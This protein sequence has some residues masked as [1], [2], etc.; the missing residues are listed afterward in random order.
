[1]EAAGTWSGSSPV[2]G[3]RTPLGRPDVPEV[4]IIGAPAVRGSG[5]PELSAPSMVSGVNPGISPA[6]NLARG[7]IPAACAASA[8]T[9]ANLSWA[10]NAPAPL[11]PR[12]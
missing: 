7:A 9:A 4:Y 1:M 6:A 5:R 12:M 11:S 10:T 2:S 8:A 3:R